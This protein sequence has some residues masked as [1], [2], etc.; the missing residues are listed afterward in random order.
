[1]DS[2]K[3]AKID[4]RS[5]KTRSPFW[6]ALHLALFSIPLR[7][8]NRYFCSNQFNPPR[9]SLKTIFKIESKLY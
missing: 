2:Q 4:P 5:I 6:I 3:R 7:D 1:M 9:I 8:L